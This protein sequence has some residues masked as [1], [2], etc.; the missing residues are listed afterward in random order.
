MHACAYACART[1][2]MRSFL[3]R[4]CTCHFTSRQFCVA[5]RLQD[6]LHGRLQGTRLWSSSL[7]LLL[8]IL[9]KVLGAVRGDRPDECTLKAF[10]VGHATAL[11]E[12]GK[13]IG[14]ILNAGE[15]CS[16]AFLSYIDEDIVDAGQVLEQVL[17]DSDCD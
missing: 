16:A 9:R 12:E 14:D 11:A 10:R 15:W 1:D 17:T 2:H 13:S 6:F 4:P 7:H 3:K 8:T 5:H